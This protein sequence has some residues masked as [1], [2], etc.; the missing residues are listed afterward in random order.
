MNFTNPFPFLIIVFLLSSSISFAQKKT[1]S[2]EGW[3]IQN[4]EKIEG[5]LYLDDWYQN[6]K[7][8]LFEPYGKDLEE[9]TPS[10]ISSFGSNDQKHF[11]QSKSIEVMSFPVGNFNED[12]KL[13]FSGEAFIKVLKKGVVSL[14]HYMDD[15]NINHFFYQSG[16]NGF[17]KLLYSEIPVNKNGRRVLQRNFFYRNQFHK[18]FSE[19]KN[20]K[21]EISMA[22]YT[23]KSLSG[24]Y[25]NYYD[26]QKLD[27]DYSISFKRNKIQHG[28][29][30]GI[31]FVNLK[32]NS[33][34][35]VH[36]GVTNFGW[37]PSPLVGYFV[38]INR[39]GDLAKTAFRFDL[40]YSNHLIS[41]NAAFENQPSI[42]TPIRLEEYDVDLSFHNI[43]LF[44]GF[45]YRF[46][47]VKLNPYLFFDL[48][49]NS[50]IKIQKN[51]AIQDITLNGITTSKSEI[52]YSKIKNP[53]FPIKFGFG[54]ETNRLILECGFQR[55]SGYS[56]FAFFPDRV[57]IASFH[58][59]YKFN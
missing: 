22:D 37:D 59:G 41:G 19:C 20:L 16:E 3:I 31:D 44:G 39:G 54:I 17:D 26:C 52:A 34:A 25:D 58:F 33:K 50:T 28:A 46:N 36:V 56:P 5:V 23:V 10:V 24:L 40:S 21:N 55:D 1:N 29:K 9:F 11:Y 32:F 57:N 12:D 6:P 45:Q 18:L 53:R 42:G 15:N 43:S 8:I 4:N 2:T 13:E 38:R 47:S 27:Y 14:F 30:L 51:E 49:F 35:L 7:V 48:G